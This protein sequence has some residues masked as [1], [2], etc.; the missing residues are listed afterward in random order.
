V[1]YQKMWSHGIWKSSNP[2]T[3][4]TSSYYHGLRNNKTCWSVC[5]K[6][7]W[8]IFWWRF[9]LLF[10]C[11]RSKPWQ[12]CVSKRQKVHRGNAQSS[13]SK[14]LVYRGKY[15][16]MTKIGHENLLTFAFSCGIGTPKQK[17]PNQVSFQT[18]M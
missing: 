2:R 13:N 8:R 12:F 15:A 14:L 7:N 16:T 17:Q 3:I 9:L 11:P 10:Y 18:C 4:S 5:I 6:R 1:V